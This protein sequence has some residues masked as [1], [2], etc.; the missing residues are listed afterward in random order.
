MFCL[1]L[2]YLLTFLSFFLCVLDIC[3][4][5]L[6]LNHIVLICI[7]NLFHIGSCY[8]ARV[9]PWRSGNEKNK[10]L[11]CRTLVPKPWL[12][13]RITWGALENCLN[14]PRG[15]SSGAWDGPSNPYIF[16]CSPSEGNNQADLG[17]TVFNVFRRN[18]AVFYC[19]S[20][21]GSLKIMYRK[22][23]VQELYIKS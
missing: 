7:Y 18:L 1:P 3:H 8:P 21:F 22:N 12:I 4:W 17:I 13:M 6:L 16:T 23:H 2:S 10:K 19:N 20:S 11:C 5:F 9:S 15:R 14:Y